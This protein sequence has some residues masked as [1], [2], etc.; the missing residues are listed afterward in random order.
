VDA[1]ERAV[2]RAGSWATTASVR[3][4]ADEELIV[5]SAHRDV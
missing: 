4:T 2:T 5:M 3:R 1:T